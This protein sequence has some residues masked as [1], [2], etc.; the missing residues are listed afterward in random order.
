M[1]G[2]NETLA[3]STYGIPVQPAI[4]NAVAPITGGKIWPPLDAAVSMAAACSG[5]YPDFFIIGMVKDPVIVI[6]ATVLP[7][8]EPK[9]A[10]VKTDKAAAPL[11]NLDAAKPPKDMM[12]R[13]P[14]KASNKDPKNIKRNK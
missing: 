4:T 11:L 8:R 13:I 3:I 9:S 6:L 10:L 2:I 12:K 1:A 7:V 14:P 5:L